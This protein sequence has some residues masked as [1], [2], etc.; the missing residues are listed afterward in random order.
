M[1]N[2]CAKIRPK[3]Y[4]LA[5][6]FCTKENEIKVELTVIYTSKINN[7]IEHTNILIMFKAKCH[8]LDTIINITQ[9]F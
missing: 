7:I 4:C 9:F 6:R 2:I 8:L 5:S 1:L 3:A